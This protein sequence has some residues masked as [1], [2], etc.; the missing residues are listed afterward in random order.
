MVTIDSDLVVFNGRV[1][2]VSPGRVL[3]SIGYRLFDSHDGGHTWRLL[4]VVRRGLMRSMMIRLPLASRLLRRGIH[5]VI[6][7]DDR[8][9]VFVDDQIK[10]LQSASFE[11]MSASKMTSSRPMVVCKTTDGVV[12]YGE[13]RSNKERSP[14][15]VYA[16]PPGETSWHEIYRFSG[17]RHVHGVFEDPYTRHIWLTTGDDDTESAIWKTSDNFDTVVKIAGGSQQTRAVQLVFTESHVYFGSDTPRE[18]NALYRMEKE[19]GVAEKL[20]AVNGSVFYG[21]TVAGNLFFTTAV[22]PSDVNTEPFAT[23]WYGG[24]DDSWMPVRAFR[25]DR[26]HPRYFQYGQIL[27]AVGPGD[28]E[29]IW[30]TP[31]AVEACSGSIRLPL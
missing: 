25:K 20:V 15:K 22:E 18:Q 16:L 23:L 21:G 1:H 8:L 9:V 6:P 3:G 5:H 13:Y 12:L 10:I 11:E 26:W 31:F 24:E 29:N 7:Q 14:I 28:G 27:V 4:G 2:Y 17:V 30:V 19:T